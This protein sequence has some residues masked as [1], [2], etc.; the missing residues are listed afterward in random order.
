MSFHLENSEPIGFKGRTIGRC[1]LISIL[2][3]FNQVQSAVKLLFV[4]VSDFSF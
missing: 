4:D 2:E 1:W 3:I